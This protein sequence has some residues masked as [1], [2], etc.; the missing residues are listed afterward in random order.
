MII[1]VFIK[2]LTV[3]TIARIPLLINTSPKYFKLTAA[4]IIRCD[5]WDYNRNQMKQRLSNVLTVIISPTM[6][7]LLCYNEKKWCLD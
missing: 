2:L 1:Q 3:I 4:L 6:N 7:N 5:S